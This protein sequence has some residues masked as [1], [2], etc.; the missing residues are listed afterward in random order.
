MTIVLRRKTMKKKDMSKIA[1]LLL[2]MVMLLSLAACGGSSSSPDS[3]DSSSSPSQEDGTPDKVI[4]WSLG[5]TDS[6]PETSSM[7]A[8]A[9][10][11][12]T[13]CDLVNERSE[14]RLVITPYYNSVLGGD[15][16]LLNDVR[17]GNLE[18]CHVNPMSGIDPRFGFKALP[19]LFED[20]D[21]V[22]ELMANPD[23]ELF[24]IIKDIC[25]EQ[26]T[27]CLAVGEG[28]LRGFL[29]SKHPVRTV[30]DLNDMTCR[31]YEDPCVSAFWS[32]I[33][34]ASIISWSECYT[35]LQTGT[36]DGLEA[37]ATISCSSKFYEVTDYYTDIDWQ[38]VGEFLILNQ[39]CWEE[40]DTDLQEIVQQAAWDAAAVE[41]E[42]AAEYREQAYTMLEDNG[43]EVTLLSDT[44]KT[45]WVEYGRSCYEPIRDIVGAETY[46]QVIEI[47][48]RSNAARNGG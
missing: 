1:A 7:N 24:Q 34:N 3:S 6:D 13:F 31:V 20:F 21:Q 2:T 10:F 15:V 29:N 37:A 45:A 33:C 30:S 5:T 22:R 28:I 4:E 12:K 8:F 14:G 39:D 9:D 43:V 17:D 23:G 18:L 35:S 16:Q 48:E 27:R 46:D 32:P 26:N 38:W 25:E 44:E 41:S 19:Y 36:V 40:L 47:L 11:T 42:K